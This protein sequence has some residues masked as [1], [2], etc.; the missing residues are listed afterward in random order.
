MQDD[1][2]CIVGLDGSAGGGYNVYNLTNSGTHVSSVA[3]DLH[4]GVLFV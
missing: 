1:G 4:M 3:V 2:S